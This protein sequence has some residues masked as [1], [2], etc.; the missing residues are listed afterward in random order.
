M[1]SAPDRTPRGRYTLCPN[2]HAAAPESHAPNPYLSGVRTSLSW[3]CE[4]WGFEIEL[5]NPGDACLLAHG[6]G[7][8]WISTIAILAIGKGG[9]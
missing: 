7:G 2:K 4:G 9:K 3:T 5:C 6:V 1:E 8:E